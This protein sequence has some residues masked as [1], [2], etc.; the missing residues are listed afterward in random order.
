MGDG[1]IEDEGVGGGVLEGMVMGAVGS[2]E[3][4]VAIQ[5]LMSFAQVGAHDEEEFLQFE[6]LAEEKAGMKAHA[7]EL[8][9]IAA[10]NDD[11][12]GMTSAAVATQDFVEGGTVEIGE[13][14]IEEDEVRGKARYSAQGLLAVGEEG[15]LPVGLVL[16]SVTK[17]G[18]EFRVIFDDDN[19]FGG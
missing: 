4:G 10:S 12:R 8:P 16:E 3:C 14:D 6:G 2:E 17:K 9:V 11:D 19:V 15:E 1:Y 7:M 13:T 5:V 18:G